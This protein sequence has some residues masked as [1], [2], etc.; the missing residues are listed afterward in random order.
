ML[1][2]ERE[3][4]IYIQLLIHLEE[5]IIIVF[6]CECVFFFI[7]LVLSFF[8]MASLRFKLTIILMTI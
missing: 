3:K 4:N 8:M 6:L 2:L 7:Y 5:V 1:E